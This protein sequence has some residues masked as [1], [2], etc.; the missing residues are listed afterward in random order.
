[1]LPNLGADTARDFQLDPVLTINSDIVTVLLVSKHLFDYL[2]R[3][4][5]VDNI[6]VY[7]HSH[8]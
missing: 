4:Q 1:M 5:T 6:V 7:L 8:Y 2:L 3:L